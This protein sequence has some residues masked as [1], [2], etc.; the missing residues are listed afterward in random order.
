MTLVQIQNKVNDYQ[1]FAP[2]YGSL[3]LTN[4]LPMAQFALYRVGTSDADLDRFTNYYIDLHNLP[5]VEPATGLS[6]NED[7]WRNYL[8]TRGY[9]A[10]FRHFFA[11]RLETLGRKKF[12]EIYFNALL[13]G[14]SSA[15]FHSLI[16]LAYGV[17][18]ENDEEILSGMA[19]L[20]DAFLE[21]RGPLPEVSTNAGS[22]HDQM[23][24]VSEELSSDR[25]VL[26]ALDGIIF[27]KMNAVSQPKVLESISKNLAIPAG[28][29][30]RNFADVALEL[31]LSTKDFTTLHTV[32]SCHA[33]RVMMPFVED[34]SS[35][36][37]YY[38][39][40]FLAAYL[41]IGAPKILKHETSLQA[42]DEKLVAAIKT[43]TQKATD[44]HDIKLTYTALQECQ[45]YQN[46]L[47]LRAA[48]ELYP[49]LQ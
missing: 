11:N 33:S 24:F 28:T 37:Q 2:E 5:S 38:Y 32:T 18:S 31:Y 43:S 41:T 46:N 21:L 8:G 16:R 23:N 35:Y 27:Q 17:D 48:V 36:L 49:D 44:D 14:I 7:N 9:F 34:E 22:L 12:L 6:L 15:A 10:D 26:P 47:Y 30:L 29:Q 19:Y 13:M 39:Q 42:S 20:A 40:A 1:N 3:N 25:L 45:S 4:H